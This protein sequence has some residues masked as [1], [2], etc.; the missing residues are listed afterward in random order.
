MK[1]NMF[2]VA[3]MIMFAM[4][5]NSVQ[6]KTA[7]CLITEGSST[8]YKG[9]CD[10]HSEKGGSFSV[11]PIGKKTFDGERSTVSVYITGKDEAHVRGLTTAGIN[12]MWGEAVRSQTQ[13]ACWVGEDFKVCAW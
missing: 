13:K 7:T 8:T 10:F 12:S 9:K 2:V 6:A 1:I 5:S 11:T 4:L 3:G